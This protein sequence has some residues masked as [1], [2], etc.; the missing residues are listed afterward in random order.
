MAYTISFPSSLMQAPN[1]DAAL[2]R[3]AEAFAAKKGISF[4]RMPASRRQGLMVSE[5][6]HSA[7]I[8]QTIGDY[9][10]PLGKY[11]KVMDDL[12]KNDTDYRMVRI[13]IL[14]EIAI[15]WPHLMDA[16]LKQMG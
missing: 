13:A 14:N 16:A 2:Y 6:R 15:H 12:A 7:L 5:I 10:R 4:E 8:S 11:D 9:R 3:Q 1:K